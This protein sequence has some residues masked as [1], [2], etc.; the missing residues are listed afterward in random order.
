[1]KILRYIFPLLII[2]LFSACDYQ[3][4]DDNFVDLDEPS[5]SHSFDLN[6][7]PESDTIIVYEKT[8]FSFD[9]NSYGVDI[10]ETDFQFGTKTWTNYNEQGSFS[11]YP[12]DYNSGTYQLTM[13]VYSKS[14]TGSIADYFGYEGYIAQKTWTVIVDNEIP[15]PIKVTRSITEDGYMK[16]TWDKPNKYRF[17]NYIV[18][19]FSEYSYRNNDYYTARIISDYNQNYFIDS[20]FYGGSGG[21]QIDLKMKDDDIIYGERFDFTDSFPKLII[22]ELGVDSI[23][24]HWKASKYRVKYVLQN[25][26]K[27][28]FSSTKDTSFTM[29]N[30]GLS[31]RLDL[32]FY[33]GSEKTDSL[34]YTNSYSEYYSYVLGTWLLSNWPV[35]AYNQVDK[36]VYSSEYDD[37]YGY[38]ITTMNKV[39]TSY[40]YRLMY[41]SNYACPTNSSQV[42]VKSP[43]YLN[44]FADKTLTNPFKIAHNSSAD[45]MCFADNNRIGVA[46]SNKFEVYDTQTGDLL[47][48]IAIDD[49][50]YYGKWASFSMSSDAKYMCVVTMNSLRMFDV[51]NGT[52]LYQYVGSYSTVLFDPKEPSQ[53][54]L[55]PYHTQHIELRNASNYSL[56]KNIPT[57]STL[58]ALDNID[59]TTGYL[60]STDYSKI[61]LYNPETS[62]LVF[63][64]KSYDFDFYPKIFN[65]I[66]FSTVGHYLDIS[67][68]LEK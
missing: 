11:L 38:D 5:S 36:M 33:I 59:P 58:N 56:I 44:I 43:G 57:E 37:V 53:F 42:A 54:Y 41:E 25:S 55:A 39:V 61:Y 27:K 15:S 66:I 3:F 23:R 24:M 26:Y 30:P 51:E 46:G 48:S 29:P 16:Y 64:V 10:W 8:D 19:F 31:N 52:L 63:S 9:V 22:E 32:T 21:C 12:S 62:E 17:K 65:N 34:D 68:Y 13:T 67:K 7:T 2:T 28:L 14:G 4:S 35:Y 50:P 20:L 1:M 6:L 60:L 40:L 47:T 45:Y 18:N 49:Y